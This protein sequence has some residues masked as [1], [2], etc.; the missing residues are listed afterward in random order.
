MTHSPADS[1]IVAGIDGSAASDAAVRWA[2]RACRVAA[3]ARDGRA[4]LDVQ[5]PGRGSQAG[6]L[7]ADLT[8]GGPWLATET[9]A[10]E[11]IIARRG[12]C[13]RQVG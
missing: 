8:R 11:A 1:R 12:R 13:G 9:V 10:S 4:T 2:V 5:R 7:A 6:Q 3:R